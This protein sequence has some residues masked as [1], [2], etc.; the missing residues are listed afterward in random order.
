MTVTTGFGGQELIEST[1]PKIEY[2]KAMIIKRGL[3]TEIEADGG[4]NK[5]NIR[6]LIDAG[7]DIATVGSAVFDR[8]NY[9]T[10]IREV[11]EQ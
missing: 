6:R 3:P 10:A 2:L 4:I 9:A 5:M 7:L 8:P 1:I 11:K